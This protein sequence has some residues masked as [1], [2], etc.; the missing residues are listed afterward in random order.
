MAAGSTII[1][2]MLTT[3]QTLVCGSGARRDT[4]FCIGT[5]TVQILPGVKFWGKYLP[6]FG[7]QLLRRPAREK[8]YFRWRPIPNRGQGIAPRREISD[9]TSRPGS[10]AGAAPEEQCNYGSRPALAAIIRRLATRRSRS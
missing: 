5:W 6:W 3:I 1:A 4:D 9:E 8:Q 10:P 7:R 2:S